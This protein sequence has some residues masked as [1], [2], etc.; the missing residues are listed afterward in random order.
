MVRCPVVS[1]HVL[2]CTAVPSSADENHQ[3]CAAKT[4]LPLESAQ[5]TRQRLN[6]M[7]VHTRTHPVPSCPCPWSLPYSVLYSR[8]QRLC[9]AC[10]QRWPVVAGYK[11]PSSTENKDAAKATASAPSPLPLIAITGSFSSLHHPLLLAF[12]LIYRCADTRTRLSSFGTALLE[13][14]LV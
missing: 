10:F 12:G 7:M 1:L 5:S 6:Q 4:N 14:K 2:Q 13:S 9:V 11:T 3:I 8:T